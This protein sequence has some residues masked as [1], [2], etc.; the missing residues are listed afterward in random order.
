[1]AIG[2]LLF[3]RSGCIDPVLPEHEGPH[4][5]PCRPKTALDIY[6]I[7]KRPFSRAQP[8]PDFWDL[9]GI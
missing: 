9:L 1:M 7:G 3:K 6:W 5:D 2:A 4:N 8:W